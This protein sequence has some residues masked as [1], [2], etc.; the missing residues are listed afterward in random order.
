MRRRRIPIHCCVRHVRHVSL[1]VLMACNA[2]DAMSVGETSHPQTH[3]TDA[4]VNTVKARRPESSQAPAN[5]QPAMVEPSGAP[6][7]M[8]QP[9]LSAP[10]IVSGG[11]AGAPAT[12][13]R[14]EDRSA[15]KAELRC[16]DGVTGQLPQ[17]YSLVAADVSEHTW[18]VHDGTLSW[19]DTSDRER[20]TVLR[21]PFG[22]DAVST[23]LEGTTSGPSLISSVDTIAADGGDLFVRASQLVVQERKVLL[24]RVP[25]ETLALEAGTG[26]GALVV[27][28]D[29][30]YWM[31]AEDA[32]INLYRTSRLS[33]ETRALGS[34]ALDWAHGG[35]TQAHVAGVVALGDS[36]YVALSSSGRGQIHR[37]AK[38]GDQ[39]FAP[40]GAELSA[41]T[42]LTTDGTDLVLVLEPELDALGNV[43]K[44]TRI[45]R[46]TQ[47]GEVHETAPIAAD[48]SYTGI[49]VAVS[50]G[51]VYWTENQQASVWQGTLWSAPLD[52]SRAPIKEL[53]TPENLL[54]QGIVIDDGAVYFAVYCR[55]DHGNEVG[56]RTHIVRFQP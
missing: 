47:A 52:G 3:S 31:A 15:G 42:G 36:L 7:N 33:N 24:R 11:A 40:L 48:G 37:V 38:G 10:S 34:V 9:P 32:R 35:V 41:I 4:P 6:T 50:G 44:T 43:Q 13:P 54:S 5:T 16:A 55:V 29:A 51:L 46:M 23:P 26:L 21:K 45:A 22:K 19:I 14:D 20:W 56:G 25:G 2:V 49:D 53:T 28:H 27:E 30:V 8:A 12:V 1:T 18:T 39:P 17:R